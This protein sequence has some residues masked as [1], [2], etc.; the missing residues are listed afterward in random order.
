MVI[1]AE[2]ENVGT[3]YRDKALAMAQDQ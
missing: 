3:F 1:D 2:G